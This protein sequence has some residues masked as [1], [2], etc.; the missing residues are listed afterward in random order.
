MKK[1]LDKKALKREEMFWS[2]I[3]KAL[4]ESPVRICRK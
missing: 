4:K 2:R 1:A 3:R